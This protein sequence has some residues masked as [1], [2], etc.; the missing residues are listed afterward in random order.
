MDLEGD[1]FVPMLH[2]GDGQL[3]A[4]LLF[5]FEADGSPAAD[6]DTVLDDYVSKKD[7]VSAAMSQPCSPLATGEG[8]CVMEYKTVLRVTPAPQSKLEA[9]TVYLNDHLIE[10]VVRVTVAPG[11]L[12]SRN[13]SSNGSRE[14]QQQQ[15]RFKRSSSSS[16]YVHYHR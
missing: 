4:A 14:Q 12:S 9:S 13:F 16:R 2:A 3:G 15:R 1:A 7:P 8:G 5:S 6:L 10:A 11:C